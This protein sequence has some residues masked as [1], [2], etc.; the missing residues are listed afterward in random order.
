MDSCYEP[1]HLPRLLARG[2]VKRVALDGEHLTCVFSRREFRLSPA[3]VTS[4]VE[5]K[6]GVI[7]SDLM[8]DF[9]SS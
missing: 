4:E 5:V 1:G 3:L 9:R 2:A 8:G 6:R 7:W